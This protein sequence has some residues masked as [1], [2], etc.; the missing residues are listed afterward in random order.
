MDEVNLGVSWSVEFFEI[1]LLEF[2]NYVGTGLKEL[3]ETVNFIFTRYGDPDIFWGEWNEYCDEPEWEWHSLEVEW[4]NVIHKQDLQE[5]DVPTPTFDELLFGERRYVPRKLLY[6]ECFEAIK[7]KAKFEAGPPRWPKDLDE[8]AGLSVL[9]CPIESEIRCECQ[10]DF[11]LPA[12]V[13]LEPLRTYDY[14]LVAQV[15]CEDYYKADWVKPIKKLDNGRWVEAEV[16]AMDLVVYLKKVGLGKVVRNID[17]KFALQVDSA[18]SRSY[19]YWVE[20]KK[21]G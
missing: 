11:I 10:V 15:P 17:L 7:F 16:R 14:D 13:I 18:Y 6:G 19:E 20:T 3:V 4:V 8:N 9:F 2:Y 1:P 12:E 5:C 21:E